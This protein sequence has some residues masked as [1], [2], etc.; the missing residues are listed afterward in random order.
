MGRFT[1]EQIHAQ[2]EAFGKSTEKEEG[3][4]A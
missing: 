2:I 1:D 3:V 4:S